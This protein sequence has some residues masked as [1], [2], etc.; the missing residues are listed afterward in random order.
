MKKGFTFEAILGDLHDDI[1]FTFTFPA[2][3]YISVGFGYTMEDAPMVVVFDKVADGHTTPMVMDMFSKN[4]HKPKDNKENIYRMVDA[5]FDN[6]TWTCTIERPLN[7]QREGRDESIALDEQ[8]AMQYAFHKA[9]WGKHTKND[10]GIFNM[11]IDSISGRVKYD[12]LVIHRDVF[13]LAHGIIM[14]IAWSILTFFVIVSGR[15][16][17]HLYNFRMILHI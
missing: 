16:M 9:K 15:Y 5:K 17:K 2:E 10:R 6:G 4:H 7:V 12:K 1:Q 8:I 13:Y 3:H 11:T 14:Y